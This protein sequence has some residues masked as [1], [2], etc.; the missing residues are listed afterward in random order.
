M[1]LQVDL[2][3]KRPPKKQTIAFILTQFAALQAG[4]PGSTLENIKAQF[5]LG[6]HYLYEK[7]V[8]EIIEQNQDKAGFDA[9]RFL[10]MLSFC[11]N[12]KEGG[13]PVF[14]GERLTR[15]NSIE[16]ATEVAKNPADAEKIKSI[17]DKMIALRN[18]VTPLIKG[19]CSIALKN[20]KS[21]SKTTAG[22]EAEPSQTVDPSMDAVGDTSDD[23]L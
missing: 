16:R 12:V 4:I 6:N 9:D 8:E 17:M 7:E 13:T 18:E 5:A 10:E 20:P 15:I 22:D 21:K 2:T 14:G 19:S 3:K 23:I 11:G 1:D